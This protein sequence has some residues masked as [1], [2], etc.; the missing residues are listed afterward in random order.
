MNNEHSRKDDIKSLVEALRRLATY[1]HDDVSVASDA[2]DMIEWL[3]G[4]T[5][6]LGQPVLDNQASATK[7]RS[8]YGTC[9]VLMTD[10]PIPGVAEDPLT[11][12]EEEFY[13]APYLIAESMTESAAK[14]ISALLGLEYCGR[15]ENEQT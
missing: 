1:H 3:A 6:E 4:R 11:L 14:E 8:W 2:A 9:G 10:Q 13:G 7:A 15:Q 12:E 5:A